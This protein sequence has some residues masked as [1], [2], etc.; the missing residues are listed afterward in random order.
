MATRT[1]NP[2]ETK[3]TIERKGGMSELTGTC[4]QEVGDWLV[5]QNLDDFR[6]DGYTIIPKISVKKLRCN[7]SDRFYA[8]MC[9]ALGVLKKAKP[10]KLKGEADIF[11][12]ILGQKRLVL[13]ECEK[14]G[15]WPF[16]I[17]L[18]QSVD[19]E[20]VRLKYFDT[21]GKFQRLHRI[22]YRKD[23]TRAAIDEHYLR[24]YEQLLNGKLQV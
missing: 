21:M 6:I 14:K 8:R 20:K 15:E 9:K 16:S 24:V 18:L 10:L 7:P 3:V 11:R 2:D 22:I 13:I 12:F 1:G 5:F 4:I 19:E 17:G 23:I